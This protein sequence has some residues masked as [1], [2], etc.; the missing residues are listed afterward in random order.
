MDTALIACAIFI[1][2]SPAFFPTNVNNLLLA[3]PL[4]AEL[5][6]TFSIWIRVG[7]SSRAAE[8]DFPPGA[9]AVV[10]LGIAV[11]GWVE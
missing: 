9:A 5:D 7:P 11:V 10:R 4:L 1:D 6:V 8:R 2:I 3:G